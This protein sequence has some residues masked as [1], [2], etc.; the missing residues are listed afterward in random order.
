MY[1]T[2]YSSTGAISFGNNGAHGV[3]SLMRIESDGDVGI[4]TTA[5]TEKLHVI[6]NVRATSF[7]KGGATSDDVLL[8]DGTT[9]SLSGLTVTESNDLSSA[10]TWANVPDANITS[11][12]VTQHE[13]DLTI[14]ESQIS[15]LN[16]FSGAY[17]DLTGK[18]TT[19][20]GAQATDITNNTTDR[21]SHTNKS[22]LDNFG[23]DAN[24]EPTYNG[25][26]IDTTIAQRDVYDG[27]DSTD[28]TISLS[29]N[30]GKV[31]NDSIP[32]NVSD[33]TNDS[34]YITSADVVNDTTP[35][36]GGNLD[37]NGFNIN[38]DS[39]SSFAIGNFNMNT[40]P[41]FAGGN[42]SAIT[43]QG[44]LTFGTSEA[45]HDVIFQTPN[46]SGNLSNAIVSNGGGGVDLY[47]DSTLALSTTT[48]GVT[49][50]DELK[51]DTIVKDGATND[52]I[53]LGDGTTTSKASLENTIDSET[54][55]EP[56][57]SSTM[58]NIVTIS[59]ANYDAAVTAGT[60]SASTIYFIQ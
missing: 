15:D 31:L 33:L 17:A 58:S 4:G 29:A 11:S 50:A 48:D 2:N 5:P 51:A 20:T 59:Q 34:G 21:H 52:D 30:Q 8:G 60:V 28:N 3:N 53:L 14:T 35:Q 45:N 56:T 36:L 39:G 42:V 47:Y 23:E 13:G 38:L 9:T 44:N 32:T 41:D 24:G 46:S 27:L 25:N 12:S 1:V 6:G 26:T 55:G 57:G 49:V 40:A 16:H 54:T 22:T 37:G 7:I 10:V 43:S 18:P 19:I